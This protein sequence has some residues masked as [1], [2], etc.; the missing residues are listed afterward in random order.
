MARRRREPETASINAVTHD[1]R[2]IA[3]VDGKK[4]FVAGALSGET[5][6]FIRRKSRRNFDE[7]E[8]LD[9]IEASPDRIDA[10]CDA[11]GRCGGCSLQHVTPAHQRT[12][13]SGTLKDNLERI[14][15]VE[16]EA[17]LQP[18][19][20][21][22]WHYRRRAR[23]AVKHVPAK[24]RTL[25]GFRERHAPF[26]TD[27]HRCEVLAKPVDDMI[28]ALSELI[29]QLS[30]RARLPQIEVAIADND[31]ALVFRVLDP[32]T[33]EDKAALTAF[34]TENQLRIYLQPRGLDSV[35]LLYPPSIDGPLCYTLAEFGL[36]IAFEPTDFVQVNSDINQR[37]V[38]FA[39]EQLQAGADDRVLDLY[40]GIGNFSL[41][42]ARQAGAVLG[43]E[44]EASLV[45]RA[46]E[47]ARRNNISNVEF[48]VADLGKIDG[49]ESW[50]KA[51]CDRLL[52]DPARSGA[53][54]VVTRMQ[55]FKP[56]RI[57]YV[58]CHPGTL[59]RDAGTLVH[60]QGYKLESAGIIDM[61]PHTA[62]VESI[63][64]FTKA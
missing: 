61:F 55:L 44:G 22:E 52:L 64:V 46:A 57:V 47:N 37:M 12:I 50:I 14:G 63:A 53:A 18:M 38:H 13:K 56:T 26:I 2:G 59:A 1:G 4:T 28:D 7:A 36:E 35:T 16:P 17:W 10:R 19:T 49:T 9:V 54:E 30:I 5:V 43:V 41:P 34:G 15:R 31:I 24:G 21:P 25:V 23:L 62:H 39:I 3:D 33:D 8:L 40:C 60:E 20:G 45:A 58:S 51:G 48:R 32:P 11:F 42:L 29:G 27:M 6:Q